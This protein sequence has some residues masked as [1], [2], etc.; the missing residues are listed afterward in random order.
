MAPW[1]A[2]WSVES[3]YQPE[4]QAFEWHARLAGKHG[5]TSFNPQY[6]REIAISL[7]GTFN[8]LRVA[9][10]RLRKGG[11]IVNLST[12]VVGLKLEGYGVYAATKAAVETM[13]AILAK[14]LRGR[15]GH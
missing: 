13:T 14:E 10:Q 5:L 8:T 3:E 11:R 6:R 15:Y 4:I 1:L 2:A 12:S 9:A 7:K